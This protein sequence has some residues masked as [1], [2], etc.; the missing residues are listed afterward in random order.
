[1]FDLSLVLTVKVLIYGQ[2]SSIRPTNPS[3]E[4]PN[5]IYN[6]FLQIKLVI[7]IGVLHVY[8]PERHP[9]VDFNIE[10]NKDF[11]K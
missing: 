2:F 10:P 7:G 9:T 5:P 8:I 1:M 6:L 11:S 4:W 3:F